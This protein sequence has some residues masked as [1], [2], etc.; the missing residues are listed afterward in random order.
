MT[1]QNKTG[2]SMKN[3]KDKRML[4]PT[5]IF[6]SLVVMVA[7]HFLLPVSKIIPF[8][9]NLLGIIPFLLGLIINLIADN[10]F[11]KHETTV[12]PFKKSTSLVTRGRVPD[13]QASHVSWIRAGF[14][15]NRSIYGLP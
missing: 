1:N 6:L 15:W 9:W 2:V 7:L 5:Y 4:P 12:K 10:D 8:Y 14:Y 3:K 11:K 13:L